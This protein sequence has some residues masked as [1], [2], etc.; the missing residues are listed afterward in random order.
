MLEQYD[1]VNFGFLRLEVSKTAITGSYLSAPY[2]ETTTPQPNVT[3]RF[4]IDLKA[5]T[6]TTG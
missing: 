6:V 2:K 4:T 3:D 5:R 1:Q